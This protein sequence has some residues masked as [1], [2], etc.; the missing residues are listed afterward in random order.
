MCSGVPRYE[1]AKHDAASS[2]LCNTNLMNEPILINDPRAA[3]M[4]IHECGEP[5]VDLRTCPLL[6]TDE[7]PHVSKRCETQLY[8]REGVARRFLEAERLLP[9]G[10]RLLILECHRPIELQRYYW[11]KDLAAL[12]ERNPDWSEEQLV[13]E[14]AKLVA[15][16]DPTP[17]HSTG[18]A[19]DVTLVDVSGATETELDM[20]VP[21]NTEGPL[22][23]MAA[24]NIS[25]E[26]KKN[27]MVLL[28]VMEGAGFTN[29]GYE[30]WHYSYGDRYWAYVRGESAAIYG[31]VSVE[32]PLTEDSGGK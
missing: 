22:S 19:A 13:T 4:P 30:W 7:H 15:P 2:T 1:D 6:A 12:R 5:L 29:Y 20:G 26:A 27:R 25:E 28:G 3:A 31:V 23:H 8:C 21:I 9:E 32:A 16:P 17:P 18:G 14:N 10:V 24:D 11:E